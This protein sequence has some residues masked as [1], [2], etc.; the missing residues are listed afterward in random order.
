VLDG[1][2]EDDTADTTETVDAD[3]DGSHFDYRIRFCLEGVKLDEEFLSIVGW[4]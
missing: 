4:C 3:L 2:A 1:V